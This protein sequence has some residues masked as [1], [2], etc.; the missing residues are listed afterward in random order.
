VCHGAGMFGDG[1]GRAAGLLDLF[2]G[3]SVGEW[4]G[5]TEGVEEGESGGGEWGGW[6]AGGGEEEEEV[7][8]G[9]VLGLWDIFAYFG[10]YTACRNYIG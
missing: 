5:F 9:G 7:D 10:P 3:E 4:L 1:V 2:A 6:D 8:V